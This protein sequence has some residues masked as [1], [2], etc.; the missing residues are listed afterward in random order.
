[1]NYTSDRIAPEYYDDWRTR[2]DD[3]EEENEEE[4]EY[5]NEED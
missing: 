3:E 5:E 1:M 2:I 4:F